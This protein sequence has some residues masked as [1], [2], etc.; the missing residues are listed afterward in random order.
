MLASCATHSV[1]PIEQPAPKA[2]DP[3]ICVPVKEEPPVQGS[4]VAPATE[5]EREALRLFLNGYAETRGWGREG[6]AIAL[7]AQ[8]HVCGP[9]L[10]PPRP[11]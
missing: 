2:P 7:L 6:W 4:V 11:G 3:R 8:K 9:P 5:E 10:K 1:P